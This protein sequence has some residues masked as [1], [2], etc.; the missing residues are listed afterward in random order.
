MRQ[1][2]R[3][4]LL[5]LL[6]ALVAAPSV[7]GAQDRRPCTLVFRGVSRAGVLT[8]AMKVFT[9]PDGTKRTYISGGVDATC[10]GQGN[11]LLADS[12]E[13]YASRGELILIDRVRY[14]DDQVRMTSTRMVYF[15]ADERLLA[16]GN[17]DG[18]TKKG[19]RFRG[20]E[21]TYL[22]PKP[23]VRA[24]AS[25]RAPGRPVVRLA[26]RRRPSGSAPTADTVTVVGDVVYSENDSLVWATGRVVISR[27][28]LDATGDSARLDEGLGLAQLRKA[29]RIVG[30]G[31]RAFTLV[32][33]EVDLWSR[34][35]ELERVR[36]N[37]AAR[38]D[39][40][41][42]RLSGDTIDLRLAEGEM[43]RVYTWGGRAAADGEAQR[44]EADSLDIRMPH[45]ELE[46][47][48]A[49]GGAV[50]YALPDTTAVRTDERDW[51]AGDTLVATFETVPVPGDTARKTRMR[52]VVAT[53]SARAF[54]QL[55]AKDAD[56]ATPN[57]SYNRGRRIT[58]RF[59]EGQVRQVDVL[60]RA[61][62]LYLEAAAK[63]D[64]TRA[65]TP[66]PQ[67]RVP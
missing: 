21:M 44:I 4:V 1:T 38:V 41:S 11:R 20:P 52:G 25:W 46:E 50:A 40:D 65:P 35:G 55:A 61:S 19:V 51:I 47:L 45:Q 17:V 31:D 28:D 62:G 26:D 57:L 8:T 56:P 29:P 12:A 10:A 48:H 24:V 39:A 59:E 36:A 66:R 9:D 33:T 14:S 42:L 58:V 53:G 7:T 3:P 54:Q 6:V 49:V 5:A 13:H 18:T 63:T 37:G 23:G 16:T 60:D 67:R 2:P 43:E 34:E 22:R 30:T 32:G 15:T 27:P 64:T